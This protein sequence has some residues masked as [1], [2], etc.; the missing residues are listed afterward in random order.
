MCASHSVKACDLVI[1]GEVLHC[2]ILELMQSTEYL[3][4]ARSD[5]DRPGAT[6]HAATVARIGK[7]LPV[8]GLPETSDEFGGSAGMLVVQ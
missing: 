2:E 4:D 1:G 6:W 5:A 7:W 8:S 3:H